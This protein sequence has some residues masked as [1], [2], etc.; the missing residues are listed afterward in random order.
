MLCSHHSKCH[1]LLFLCCLLL[2]H[3]LITLYQKLF[4]HTSLFFSLVQPW[5][6]DDFGRNLSGIRVLPITYSCFLKNMEEFLEKYQFQSEKKFQHFNQDL[7]AFTTHSNRSTIRFYLSHNKQ[8]RGKCVAIFS[9]L[10]EK[11]HNSHNSTWQSFQSSQK[12]SITIVTVDL[13]MIWKEHN[14]H[15]FS[16][17]EPV[18]PQCPGLKRYTFGGLNFHHGWKFQLK[19]IFGRI[20]FQNSSF[21]I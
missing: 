17:F 4:L 11:Y 16:Q 18:R 10:T 9:V 3:H 12:K 20:Y 6:F 19:R 15:N 13:N 21:L 8:E 14:S 7:S 1:L 2:F 5:R